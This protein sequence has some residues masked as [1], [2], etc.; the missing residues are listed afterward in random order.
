[1]KYGSEEITTQLRKET[2]DLN[3]KK[4]K[5]PWRNEGVQFIIAVPHMKKSFHELSE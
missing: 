5:E 4:V 3:M 2:K 1:M